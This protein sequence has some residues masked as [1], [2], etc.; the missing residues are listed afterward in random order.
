[1]LSDLPCWTLYARRGWNRIYIASG[2]PAQRPLAESLARWMN[3]HHTDT[4][5]GFIE[6]RL[7]E[8]LDGE[9]G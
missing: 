4:W 9:W 1:M 8:I 5:D 2:P 7:G 3:E 6:T